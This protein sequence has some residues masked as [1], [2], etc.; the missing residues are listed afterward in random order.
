MNKILFAI[1]LF[2]FGYV[3]SEIIN[4]NKNLAIKQAHAQISEIDRYVIRGELVFEHAVIDIIMDQCMVDV[5]KV[6]DNISQG[7][8]LCDKRKF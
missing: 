7:K 8:V 4:D 2:F 6:D 1:G 3:T 5:K